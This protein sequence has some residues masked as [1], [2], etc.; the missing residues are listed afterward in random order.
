MEIRRYIEEDR[1]FLRTLYL[2]SRKANWHWLNAS[3]WQLEDFDQIIIGERVWVA[4]EQGYRVGFA[5]VSVNDNFLHSLY[6]APGW[7]RRGIGSALL[8]EVET[9]FTSIGALKCLS[10]NTAALA[11]YLQRG[12]HRVSSG[13]SE[14]GSYE[15]MHLRK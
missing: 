5:A 1:P 7:Q 15:L 10:A 14:L 6:I 4:I 3:A 13:E 2:A 8:D 12:W 9:T 11:F